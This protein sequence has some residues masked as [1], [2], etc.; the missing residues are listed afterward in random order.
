M[1]PQTGMLVIP[2]DNNKTN[3][4]DLADAA[5][6][7][8]VNNFIEVAKNFRGNNLY[9]DVVNQFA[10]EKAK[11]VDKIVFDCFQEHLG[12]KKADDVFVIV[13]SPVMFHRYNDIL[14]YINEKLVQEVGPLGSPPECIKLGELT[15]PTKGSREMLETLR[16]RWEEIYHEG[17]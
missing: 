15:E 17:S 4:P 11:E 3:I 9:E 12:C 5:E 6:K 7:F 16:T 14:P 2:D 8:S 13:T 1:K 10:D